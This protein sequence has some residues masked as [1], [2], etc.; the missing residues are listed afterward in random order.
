M[1]DVL[2]GRGVT[3]AFGGIRAVD[4]V[5][6]E[7]REAEILGLIGPNGAGKTSLLNC[8]SQVFPLASGSL[9]YLGHELNGMDPSRVARL[10]VGRTFQI[11]RPFS[12]LTACENVAV[13]AMFGAAQVS[14]REAMEKAMEA[15]AFVG[16]TGCARQ[17][18]ADIPTA[19]RKHLELARAL[20][21]NPKL[22]LLDEVL[23]GVSPSAIEEVIRIILQV[24][25]RGVAIVMVEH[26]VRPMMRIS[27]R[28]LV[29]HHGRQLALGTPAEV[30]NDPEVI[31]AY[32][33]ERF[34]QGSAGDRIAATQ[35]KGGGS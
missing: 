25:E 17:R 11:V 29:L 30:S 6:F 19:Y 14:V 18:T 5:D 1:T 26:V 7:V 22:L 2:V 13:G 12:G 21:M 32:L 34:K 4:G 31:S 16:L 3:L 10:G 8:I 23:A 33:G 24:R 20:C 27:D 15:L 9:R 35:A 28:V